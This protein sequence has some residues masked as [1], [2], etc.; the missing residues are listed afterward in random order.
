M[1]QS[2]G[3]TW[4]EAGQWLDELQREWGVVASVSMQH[5]STPQ[6][7]R[8]WY[9]RLSVGKNAREC[10]DAPTAVEGSEFPTNACKSVP[11]LLLL[12]AHRLGEKL[13]ARRKEA[14]RQAAF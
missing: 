11:A 14:E 6:G 4:W 3:I 9:V 10:V 1:Q 7:K 2:N 12:L 8:Y 13:D 5:L